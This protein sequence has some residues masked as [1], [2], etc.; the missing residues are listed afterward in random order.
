MKG[1]GSGLAP[2]RV[3][4]ISYHMSGK[5]KVDIHEKCVNNVVT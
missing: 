5:Q 3:G 1:W 2:P 4:F